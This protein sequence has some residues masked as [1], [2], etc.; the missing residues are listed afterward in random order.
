MD[1]I[2]IFIIILTILLILFFNNC[3]SL[4]I[5]LYLPFLGLIHLFSKQYNT[6]SKKGGK[7]INKYNSLL[8]YIIK[9]DNKN[10]GDESD[11]KIKQLEEENNKIIDII[12]EYDSIKDNKEELKQFL[13]NFNKSN[14]YFMLKDVY[15][16]KI[17]NKIQ[18]HFKLKLNDRLNEFTDKSDT[19]KNKIN[20]INTSGNL[21]L[22][23]ENEI[24]ETIAYIIS[25][26]AINANNNPL[27]N[28]LQ[29]YMTYDDYKIYYNKNKYTFD[30]LIRNGIQTQKNL[31]SALYINHIKEYINNKKI[32]V[33]LED[34]TKDINEKIKKLNGSSKN[35]L[36]IESKTQINKSIYI[37]YKIYRYNLYNLSELNKTKV[38]TEI[39]NEN[40]RKQFEDVL[41]E[42]VIKTNEINKNSTI[43]DKIT[44]L[45]TNNYII[46]KKILSI[47][48]YI[49]LCEPINMVL[50]ELFEFIFGSTVNY[51]LKDE[52]IEKYDI[53]YKKLLIDKDILK[54]SYKYYE[55]RTN[56]RISA[57]DYINLFTGVLTYKLDIIN[58]LNIT[59]NND[60]TI[61]LNN[62]NKF[63]KYLYQLKDFSQNKFKIKSECYKLLET[64]CNLQHINIILQTDKSEII[65]NLEYQENLLE[66]IISPKIDSTVD[67]TAQFEDPRFFEEL[68]HKLINKS[69][70]SFD[71]SNSAEYTSLPP[72]DLT[73]D[74]SNSTGDTSL[75]LSD[76]T[77]AESNSIG[78]TKQYQQ[79]SQN[80][81]KSR[82]LLNVE[83]SEIDKEKLNNYT[84]KIDI[85]NDDILTMIKSMDT[86]FKK[87]IKN[88]DKNTWYNYFKL[89]NDTEILEDEILSN[90]TKKEYDLFKN[91]YTTKFKLLPTV[92]IQQS[93]P[94]K[95]YP[96]FL[97]VT[98]TSY[99][100]PDANKKYGLNGKLADN[101]S[102]LKTNK[103]MNPNKEKDFLKIVDICHKSNDFNEKLNMDNI[104]EIFKINNLNIYDYK[105]QYKI[106]KNEYNTS[107]R[108][109][110]NL[111]DYKQKLLKEYNN[112]NNNNIDT[113]ILQIA[114]MGLF[115]PLLNIS[116]VINS[117]NFK[118]YSLYLSNLER[119]NIYKKI[120]PYEQYFNMEIDELKKEIENFKNKLESYKG[121]DV[122]IEK[123]NIEC[124]LAKQAL[125][126]KIKELNKY[127]IDCEDKLKNTTLSLNDLILYMNKLI[128][129]INNT[130]N[131]HD[132][133]ELK[134]N[135]DDVIKNIEDNNEINNLIIKLESIEDND[136]T[137]KKNIND[138]KEYK[139]RTLID[140]NN[141]IIRLLV[142]YIEKMKKCED[143]KKKLLKKSKLTNELDQTNSQVNN[144]KDVLTKIDDEIEKNNKEI[145]YLN[146]NKKQQSEQ[147]KKTKSLYDNLI[148]EQQEYE[149]KL[150]KLD[151][152][153]IK[154]ETKKIQD[155]E[156]IQIKL[157]ENSKKIELFKKLKQ[158]LVNIKN[159]IEAINQ[160]N[161]NLESDYILKENEL[162]QKLQNKETLNVN[163]AQ[164]G[165]EIFELNKLMSSTDIEL[166]TLQDKK[167]LTSSELE[168]KKNNI[169]KLKEDIQKITD[170][171]N[172]LNQQ[173]NIN[174]NDTANNKNQTLDEEI[175]RLTDSKNKL[176][177]QIETRSLELKTS[178]N[179][180]EKL[181][182]DIE[183]KKLQI[184]KLENELKALNDKS[185]LITT[186]K[187][188]NDNEYKNTE[189]T[190]SNLNNTLN[191]LNAEKDGLENELSQRR[192][193]I[194]SKKEQINSNNYIID[195]INI[196]LEILQKNKNS[197][198]NDPTKNEYIDI[199]NKLTEQIQKIKELLAKQDIDTT[200]YNEYKTKENE[201]KENI[202]DKQKN[203]ELLQATLEQVNEL[204]KDRLQKLIEELEDKQKEL[205]YSK[206][207]IKNYE[208]KLEAKQK[209]SNELSQYEAQLE[210]K[211]KELNNLSEQYTKERI[212]LETKQK[213][214][215]E[216]LLE[217]QT[218]LKEELEAK[219]NELRQLQLQN[220]NTLDDLNIKHNKEL[221][222]LKKLS[223]SELFN[224][225]LDHKKQ[226]EE[227]ELKHK[228]KLDNALQKKFDNDQKEYDEALNKQKNSL[229]AE[230]E[231]QFIEYQK[232]NDEALN[233]QKNS[234]EAE[235]EAKFIEYQKEY[236]EALNKQKAEFEVKQ[237]IF[238]DKI[239]K[240][241]SDYELELNKA[242]DQKKYEFDTI[243][244]NQI[245]KY[246]KELESSKEELFKKHKKE[247]DEKV[248][249]YQLKLDEQFKQHKEEYD[250]LKL[251]KEQK[252]LNEIINT[253]IEKYNKSNEELVDEFNKEIVN[254]NDH[255]K[256]NKELH[257][258]LYK[259]HLRHIA[260]IKKLKECDS[261]KD[262]RLKEL[263]KTIEK[264]TKS[265]DRPDSDE[266]NNQDEIVKIN[267]L[268][269][270]LD[271]LIEDRNRLKLENKTLHEEV[272]KLT[273]EKEELSQQHKTEI[274]K[275]NNIIFQ[276]LKDITELKNKINDMT[277]EYI[278]SESKLILDFN[279]QIQILKQNIN[280]KNKEI[281]ILNKTIVDN[282]SKYKNNIFELQKQLKDIQTI[283]KKEYEQLKTDFNIKENDYINEITKLNSKIIFNNDLQSNLK[284]ERDQYII[285]FNKYKEDYESKL[286]YIEVLKSNISKCNSELE[287]CKEKNIILENENNR[288]K[289]LEEKNKELE[290]ENEELK[291]VLANIEDSKYN[292]N[293]YDNHGEDVY[294]FVDKN[295]TIKPIPTN[296]KN[297][298]KSDIFRLPGDKPI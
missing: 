59:T 220:I 183:Q 84:N 122:L 133:I 270:I 113:M 294:I 207:E 172:G 226:I 42:L 75:P 231:A 67:I 256:R 23:N 55:M 261:L 194:E 163:I 88:K 286:K 162:K 47:N 201:T 234:L 139:N 204:S 124:D 57:I 187:I 290:N 142:S 1:Y 188:K 102:V 166:K 116:K 108:L 36:Y 109:N 180:L 9:K 33:D 81:L 24:K 32:E 66:T 89:K 18:N 165:S 257:D 95:L 191:D 189:S 127:K 11:N 282:E 251:S 254:T 229:E 78:D 219:K 276:N 28:Y 245:E 273:L 274:K 54:E 262:L 72:S 13:N 195:Q 168:K 144:L 123:I 39:K 25:L 208:T 130:N 215:I 107:S 111:S 53:I 58:S 281:E 77:E 225:K 92:I 224:L 293:L 61:I 71:E 126:D 106:L 176:N 202:I 7:N 82:N 170:E 31:K 283:C 43:L 104:I 269:K 101:L 223:E 50:T 150:N 62:I 49:K 12:F 240:K 121:N 70:L 169:V 27:F 248:K 26:I 97:T 16:S 38:L 131:N 103:I 74:E 265:L 243:N 80:T 185:E 19:L 217:K 48:E 143:D 41:A 233:K 132:A 206:E 297:K 93:N 3:I 149:N 45:S 192:E 114:N 2:I 153:I 184:S 115:E 216:P 44:D 238:N 209:E 155:N 232:E 134:K 112:N 272:N 212:Q 34:L 63:I 140:I 117:L 196:T 214:L 246:Q 190:R 279:T 205:L 288:L 99:E 249:E 35:T 94:E 239:V 221:N 278:N 295:I 15:D 138:I 98:T 174:A 277:E 213:E 275:I 175:N 158:D 266:I 244:K 52:I 241:A 259:I 64:F 145:E 146:N 200:Q 40:V 147:L 10:G 230:R 267:N 227:I 125:E 210:A 247:Y 236:D 83:L 96:N 30:I 141:V 186:E 179:N 129:K 37:L 73:E 17:L 60:I 110:T 181:G 264:I 85:I 151:N 250:T 119:I 4:P 100:T 178:K 218:K 253:Y 199:D 252:D 152:D 211:Q 164:L 79:S 69:D 171:L 8:S 242:V 135:I 6:I 46:D 159:E 76:L 118:L 298:I 291:R 157:N 255:S 154:L 148:N 161:Q 128:N 14:K 56:K 289:S 86:N 268:N 193:L 91:I 263:N 137:I 87:N 222:D 21:K 51:L 292:Q 271:E 65:L 120:V 68:K 228:E 280:T 136:A 197:L 5:I 258:N 198:I 173:S 182:N 237:K 296:K 90:I 287:K 29:E 284:K 260:L 167:N 285:K 160:D 105:N 20:A 177:T 22:N 235:R 203:L 156:Q